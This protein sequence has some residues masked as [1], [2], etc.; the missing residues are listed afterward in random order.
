VS[1]LFGLIEDHL[2]YDESDPSDFPDNLDQLLAVRAKLN[3]ISRAARELR[4][5]A[6]EKVGAL[7]GPGEKYEYGDSIVSWSK[8]YR[9]KPVLPALKEWVEEYVDR[10]EIF[11]LFPVTAVR[12]TGLEKVAARHNFDPEV[13]VASFLE[14]V[15]DQTPRVKFKPKEMK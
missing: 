2:A 9:W 10:D 5:V 13:A 15:W 12:K 7:L 14:K 1:D 11:D 6:D 4:Q 3:D 8:G